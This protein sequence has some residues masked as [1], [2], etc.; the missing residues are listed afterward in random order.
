[1]QTITNTPVN[2]HV[3]N[4]EIEKFFPDNSI[5]ITGKSLS[6]KR[7]EDGRIMK[8]VVD[9]SMTD[10]QRD[11]FKAKF[12]YTESTVEEIGRFDILHNRARFNVDLTK[13]KK[14]IQVSMHIRT[15]GK[16][17]NSYMILLNQTERSAP[18]KYQQNNTGLIRSLRIPLKTRNDYGLLN[19]FNSQTQIKQG[20]IQSSSYE[21]SIAFSWNNTTDYI[22]YFRFL[23]ESNSHFNVGTTVVV[24]GWD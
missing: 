18:P 12:F 10:W 9:A 2:R 17:H 14:H 16:L 21:N 11:L 15:I 24:H 7:D 8:I 23:S 20:T 1:M 4:A 3:T 5:D 19:V 6:I 22:S 13:N